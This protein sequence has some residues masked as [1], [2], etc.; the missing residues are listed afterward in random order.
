MTRTNLF[1]KIEVE[2]EPPEK[3]ERIGAEICRQAH[4]VYGVRQAEL[5]NFT[6]L[7]D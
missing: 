3:P 1:F 2:Y 7:E 5:T 6:I 4:K